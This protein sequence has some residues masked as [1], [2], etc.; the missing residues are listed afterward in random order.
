MCKIGIYLV[1]DYPNRN[2]FINAVETCERKG[3]DFL[4]IGIPFS[5]PTADGDYIERASLEV[6][7]RENLENIYETIKLARS[8]FKKRLYLMTY[9]NI[10]F[11]NGIENFAN[12]FSFIDGVI[13][14][15]VPFKECDRFKSVFKK[16][17]I[18]FVNFV[19]PETDF[20][21]IDRIKK[22]ANDFIYFV[23]IRGTTGSR[24]ELDGDAKER[25]EYLKNSKQDV[26]VGFGIRTK[27]DIK[28]ACKHANGVVIGTAAVKALDE[29]DFEGFLNRIMT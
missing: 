6:I 19:T 25:L 18:G 5:D 3:V 4:E 11:A 16:K 12:R 27:D 7:K 13:L 15:D 1:C 17:K 14:A 26:I 29:N 22:T 23:S 28:E 8:I 9:A 20:N 24:F 2:K 10:V 21:T